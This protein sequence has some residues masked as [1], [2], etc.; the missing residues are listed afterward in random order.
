MKNATLALLALLIG[1]LWVTTACTPKG[2]DLLNY[3]VTSDRRNYL[4]LEAPYWALVFGVGLTV[5]ERH[6]LHSVEILPPGAHSIRWEGKGGFVEVPPEYLAQL[7]NV[8]PTGQ[9]PVSVPQPVFVLELKK[10]KEVF[11]QIP[12]DNLQGEVPLM[13]GATYFISTLYQSPAHAGQRI[14][15]GYPAILLALTKES[16][17]ELR[18]QLAALNTC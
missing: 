18:R 14:L 8:L 4:Q 9:A 15:P 7:C 1:V 17:Q 13:R 11:L 5:N 6:N 2:Q 3:V 12:F 16:W 10:G